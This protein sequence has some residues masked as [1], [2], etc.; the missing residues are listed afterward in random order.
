MAEFYINLS[1]FV[2]RDELVHYL[3]N[4]LKVPGPEP[5]FPTGSFVQSNWAL[6]FGRSNMAQFLEYKEKNFPDTQSLSEDDI[7]LEVDHGRTLANAMLFADNNFAR[8]RLLQDAIADFA[9][10]RPYRASFA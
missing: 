3:E 10:G 4:C 6:I 8:Y 9:S 7:V 1:P 2:N 5:A